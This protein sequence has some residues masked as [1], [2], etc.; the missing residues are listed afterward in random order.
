[1]YFNDSFPEAYGVK[2]QAE[3][4]NKP[5]LLLPESAREGKDVNAPAWAPMPWWPAWA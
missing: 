3:L 1:M 5:E 2:P 4:S